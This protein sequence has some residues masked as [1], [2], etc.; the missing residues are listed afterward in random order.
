MGRSIDARDDQRSKEAGKDT[1]CT[2]GEVHTSGVQVGVEGQGGNQR[3]G[4][5]SKHD[6][7]VGKVIKRRG[8][9][10]EEAGSGSIG[11][12]DGDGKEDDRAA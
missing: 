6:E 12:D 3:H 5:G 2:K 7:A 1:G 9:D 8:G 10:D 4:Q 11:E